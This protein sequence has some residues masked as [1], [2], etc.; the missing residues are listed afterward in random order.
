VVVLRRRRERNTPL[1]GIIDLTLGALAIVVG[2][3]VASWVLDRPTKLPLPN[4]RLER[5]TAPA[6]QR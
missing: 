6:Y 3:L 1:P 2:M 4:T 5:S